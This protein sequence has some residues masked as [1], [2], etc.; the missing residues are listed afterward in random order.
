M[1]LQSPLCVYRLAPYFKPGSDAVFVLTAI[2][3]AIERQPCEA[4]ARARPAEVLAAASA[5]LATVG[6]AL[7]KTFDE[8]LLQTLVAICLDPSQ[9]VH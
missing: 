2:A 6:K 5:E 4:T 1:P 7:G 8:D 3:R 9:I